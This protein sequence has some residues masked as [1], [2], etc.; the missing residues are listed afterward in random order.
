MKF[1]PKLFSFLSYL[2]TLKAIKRQLA[3]LLTQKSSKFQK[4]FVK[5]LQS[6]LSSL[7]YLTIFEAFKKQLWPLLR[8]DISKYTKI[9]KKIIVFF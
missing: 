6:L 5:V 3:L 9:K 7:S 1:L 2:V 8:V 4:D